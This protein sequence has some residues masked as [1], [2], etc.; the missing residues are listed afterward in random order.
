MLFASSR[1][2]GIGH[3]DLWMCTRNT[4]DGEWSQAV[5]VGPAINTRSAERGPSLSSD[6]LVLMFHSTRPGGEGEGDLWLS[7]RTSL[8][9]EWTQPIPLGAGINSEQDEIGPRLSMDGR[10]LLFASNRSKSQARFHLLISRGASASGPWLKP[11]NLWTNFDTNQADAF[12]T[13]SPDSQTLIFESGRVGNLGGHDLWMSRRV[14][15]IDHVAQALELADQGR[16]DDAAQQFS[17]ALDLVTEGKA[18]SDARSTIVNQ[19]IASEKLFQRVVDLRPQ[20]IDLW[21]DRGVF[22]ADRAQWQEA[23]NCFAKRLELGRAG[24]GCW[25]N[26]AMVFLACG[27]YERYREVCSQIQEA[28]SRVPDTTEQCSA[29][30]TLAIIPDA[31]QDPEQALAMV[32]RAFLQDPDNHVC[33]RAYIMW[34][35]RTERLKAVIEAIEQLPPDMSLDSDS[36]NSDINYF[37]AMAQSRLGNHENARVWSD[38][39]AERTEYLRT[40]MGDSKVPTFY[41]RLLNDEM[42]RVLAEAPLQAERPRTGE[43]ENEPLTA[44]KPQIEE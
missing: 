34:L 21:R 35:Y 42:N 28:F 16:L 7:R 18:E 40:R 36:W 41:A 3:W 23:A 10:A 19:F 6:G 5:N 8:Q 9:S 15:R 39:A 11:V 24:A 22:L 29:A 25:N 14:P 13:L 12:P 30:R 4:L 38:R 20:D 43:L 27:D 2:G 31:I 17:L 26:Y 1:A 33:R 32:E 44:P 37:A